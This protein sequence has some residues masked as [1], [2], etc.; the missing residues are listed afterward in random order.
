MIWVIDA[1]VAIRWFIE[2]EAHPH[3]DEVLE[4]VIDK[5]ERFAVPELFAFGLFSVL[6]RIHPSGLEA[7]RKGIIPL[8]QGGIFRHPMTENLALIAE[9]FVKLGRSGYDACYAALARDL[10]GI[11]ITFDEQ[12]HKL[13]QKEKM[14]FLLGKRMPPNWPG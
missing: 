12:A 10:K 14:S 9:S 6:Q 2:E 1:S 7:F 5:P 3:A 13:I 4:K 8:L 11:W